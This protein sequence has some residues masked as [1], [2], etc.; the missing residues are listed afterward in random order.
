MWYYGCNNKEK[1]FSD[2]EN[3]RA[4]STGNIILS[5]TALYVT[6]RLCNQIIYFCSMFKL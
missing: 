4:F 1:I 6:N 2:L 3:S 5:I